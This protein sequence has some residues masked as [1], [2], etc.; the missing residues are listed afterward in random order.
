MTDAIRRFL[1]I[2][3]QYPTPLTRQRAG[4]LFMMNLLLFL[5]WIIYIFY[6]VAPMLASGAPVETVIFLALAVFP[7]LSVAIHRCL[8]TGRLKTA[9]WLF[10][11]LLGVVVL[12]FIDFDLFYTLPIALMIP[13]V[14]AGVLLD[15]RGFSIV[16]VILG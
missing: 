14:A 9:S 4:G 3:Y 7:F 5:G 11:I 8:Q 16:L 2:G 6:S 12:P 10:V 1:T 13:M 15:R